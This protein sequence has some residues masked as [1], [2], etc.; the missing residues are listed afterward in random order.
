MHYERDNIQQMSGYT[1]GEQPDAAGI[2]KLNTNENPLAALSRGYGSATTA[3]SRVAAPLSLTQRGGVFS[4]SRR[5]TTTLIARNW[6]RP[7]AVMS[8]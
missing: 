5:S 8:S 6:S 7:T 4:A 2:I 3:I 1:P